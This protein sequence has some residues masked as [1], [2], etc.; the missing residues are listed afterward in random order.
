MS[1]A[2]RRLGRIILLSV[3]GFALNLVGSRFALAANLPLF[4]DS[5]GTMLVAA[6]CGVIPGILVG[7]ATNMVNVMADP[8]SLYYGVL[9]VLIAVFAAFFARRGYFGK[10][11]GIVISILTFTA[12]GGGLGSV[13]TWL[14]YGF[15]FG[16]GISAPLAHYFY[17]HGMESVFW[18]QFAADLLIDL[19]DKTV[20]VLICVLVLRLLSQKFKEASYLYGWR[21][22]PLSVKKQESMKR[23]ISLS[24]SLRSKVMV[25][26]S[27]AVLL[28]AI[29]V[30]G[31]SYV[32]FY[33]SM[34]EQQKRLGFGVANVVSSNVDANKVDQYLAEGEAVEGYLETKAHLSHVMNSTPDIEYVYVYKI[35]EDGCHVVFDPDTPDTK[36][37]APGTVIAFDDAFKPYLPALLNGKEIEPIVSNET[38]GW[39][40]TIYLPMYDDN[41]ECQSYAGVDISMKE[42][43][44]DGRVFLTKVIALFSGFFILILALAAWLLEY[45]IVLPINSM[46]YV[47]GKFAYDSEEARM[48]TV[49]RIQNL[50]IDTGDEIENLYH[51]MTKTTEDTVSYITDAQKKNDEIARL[52]NGLIMVLADLVES[53][54]KCTGDHVKNTAAYAGIIIEEM[55][56]EGIYEDQLTDDFVYDVINS[57]PLHDVG[58]IHVPDALLNKP[59]RLT[60]EEFARMKEHTT[61][62]SEILEKAIDMVSESES[63]YLKEA[64]NLAE[65]H[66]EK[67]D[68][69]GYPCGLKGEEIP[70]SARIMAVADVFD[71]LVSRRS[72]KEGF[73]FEQAM[74]IIREGSG[75][76]FDPKVAEAF[77][78]AEDEVR[79]VAEHRGDTEKAAP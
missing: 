13:I 61:A 47:A 22:K 68:G 48:D 25:C 16:E 65:Y 9:S 56:K 49:R 17:G 77:L 66:H 15:G 57:A 76:H 6:I 35:M 67:W 7:F 45:N 38:Y 8:V 34:I 58:K 39:L 75:S 42:I 32:L 4:L 29:V 3:I 50:E 24:K 64:R 43:M 69:S 55:R 74:E 53:R 10:I 60:D 37:E 33:D 36:G 52:Q 26:L 27:V 40:L 54:D 2:N 62:G 46:A 20:S 71:A 18:A 28:I 78:N 11:K 23:R 59:G 1:N 51:A 79:K 31:V 19:L 21:Q 63:G 41:G 72:Y 5:F 30:T 44:A 14:L 12:I 73:P 70:L